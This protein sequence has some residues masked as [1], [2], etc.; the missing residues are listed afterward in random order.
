MR[1]SR[2][3]HCCAALRGRGN[4]ASAIVAAGRQRAAGPARCSGL[5][6]PAAARPP[7]LRRRGGRRRRACRVP[8]AR[9]DARQRARRP[10]S[11]DGAA[12]P[13][14]VVLGKGDPGSARA[15]PRHNQALGQRKRRRVRCAGGRSAA[16]P[17]IRADQQGHRWSNTSMPRW[18]KN[19][20][21]R[22]WRQQAGDGIA[23]A[24][25]SG[26]MT[27]V[28][29][30]Q[31]DYTWEGF[32]EAGLESL[33]G[34]DQIEMARVSCI[35]LMPS[36]PFTSCMIERTSEFC[37]AN[38]IKKREEHQKHCYGLTIPWVDALSGWIGK[39]LAD[40]SPAFCL[41]CSHNCLT[42]TQSQSD[43]Q[44]KNPKVVVRARAR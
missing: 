15:R 23:S 32:K 7:I 27:A 30:I 41:Y 9:P 38:K 6:K 29:M 26:D 13:L 16:Q 1:G 21:A 2:R 12:A 4:T 14:R 22:A 33:V 5:L 36:I 25:I 31:S 18:S 39:A 3:E 35:R 20:D 42:T 11:G 8:A 43:V 44:R 17:M 10:P 37:S 24:E 34:Q 40:Q 19:A 28:R